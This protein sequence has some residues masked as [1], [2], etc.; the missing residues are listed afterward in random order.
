MQM[1]YLNNHVSFSVFFLLLFAATVN[2]VFNMETSKIN[3]LLE[4]FL[5]KTKPGIKQ[6]ILT[7]R[8]L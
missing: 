4:D 7:I 3:S 6:M 5:K 1:H 8:P 2:K